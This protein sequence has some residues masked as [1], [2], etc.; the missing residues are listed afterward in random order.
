MSW[1]IVEHSKLITSLPDIDPRP[2]FLEK[3]ITE[4]QGHMNDFFRSGAAQAAAAA[5]EGVKA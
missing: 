4:A 2:Q 5:E 3:Q 1:V